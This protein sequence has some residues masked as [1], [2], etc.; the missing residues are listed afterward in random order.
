MRDWVLAQ[1]FESSVI[2]YGS[3]TDSSRGWCSFRFES[4][5]I[6]YGSQTISENSL[7]IVRFES[8]VI[9]YGSQTALIVP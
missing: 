8:S 3:Q 6:S 7:F 9:S 2:S 4:S 5:V 1:L